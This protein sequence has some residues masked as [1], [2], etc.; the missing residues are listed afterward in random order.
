MCSRVDVM[1]LSKENISIIKSCVHQVF[2]D[3]MRVFLFGSRTDCSKRGGDIDLYLLPKKDKVIVN[4][5]NKKIEL[6][7]ILEKAIGE[8]KI[9]VVLAKTGDDKRLIDDVALREGIEL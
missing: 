9:D 5:F 4:G 2:G 3:D 1:R 7:V 8:Q 6:L